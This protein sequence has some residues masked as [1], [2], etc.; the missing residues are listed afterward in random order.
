VWRR[1]CVA[2]RPSSRFVGIPCHVA[3]PS[4]HARNPPPPPSTTP[5]HPHTPLPSAPPPAGPGASGAQPEGG[6]AAQVE[7]DV[8]DHLQ[9][10]AGRD[11]VSQQ[12]GEGTRAWLL[13]G[14]WG[15][16]RHLQQRHHTVDLCLNASHNVLCSAC[17]GLPRPS[18]PPPPPHVSPTLTHMCRPAPLIYR[19]PLTPCP[20]PLPHP[21]CAGPPR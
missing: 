11:Q 5:T 18:L 16:R 4:S 21:Y 13:S 9:G 7:G 15:R 14:R 6:A 12:P 2:L 10:A 1:A 8:W 3:L 20:P 17:T 19:C